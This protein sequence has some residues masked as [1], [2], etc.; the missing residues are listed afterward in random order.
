MAITERMRLLRAFDP[1]KVNLRHWSFE[2]NAYCKN[3]DV[4][5]ALKGDKVKGHCPLI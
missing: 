4:F 1:T 5:P 2:I 3:L